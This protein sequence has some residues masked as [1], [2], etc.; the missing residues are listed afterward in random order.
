[1]MHELDK[2]SQVFGDENMNSEFIVLQKHLL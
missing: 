2:Y 1:M